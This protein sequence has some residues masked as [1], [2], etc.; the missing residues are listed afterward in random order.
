[1]PKRRGNP[2]DR[3]RS[4][5]IDVDGEDIILADNYVD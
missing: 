2:N 4:I 3:H 1:V 5:G